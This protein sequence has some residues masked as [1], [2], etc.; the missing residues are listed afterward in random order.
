M[1]EIVQMELS[2]VPTNTASHVQII[3]DNVHLSTNAQVAMS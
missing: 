3:A 1:L 2:Q